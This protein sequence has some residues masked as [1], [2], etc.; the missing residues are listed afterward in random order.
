MIIGSDGLKGVVSIGLAAVICGALL[1]C[2][3]PVGSPVTVAEQ[4]A[5]SVEIGAADDN[6]DNEWA[7]AGDTVGSQGRRWETRWI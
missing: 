1:S 3:G 4:R 5:P 2:G 6:E 7:P